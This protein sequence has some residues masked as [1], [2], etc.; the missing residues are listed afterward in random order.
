[1]RRLERKVR[2][3]QLLALTLTIDEDLRMT[4]EVKV[5]LCLAQ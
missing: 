3:G 1:M 2:T 5:V 4:G